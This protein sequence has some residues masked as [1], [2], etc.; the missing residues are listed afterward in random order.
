MK[1]NTIP[2]P[3]WNWLHMNEVIV[4][5]D[6]DGEEQ[7]IEIT[8]NQK[9]LEPLRMKIHLE[10]EKDGANGFDFRLEPKSSLTVIMN[11]TSEIGIKAKYLNKIKY[12]CKEGAKLTLIQVL[13]AGDK[14]EVFHDIDGVCESK[15]EFHLI[16]LVLGGKTTNISCRNDLVG[17]EGKATID[18][19]YLL[20]KKEKLDVNYVVNHIG[21]KT[22]CDIDVNGVLKDEA[23]KLFRGTIDFKKGASGSVG[24]EMEDVL[25][26][27]EDIVNQSLPV[28]LCGEED[29]EGNHGA[30]IGELNED[31]M[32][33]MESR[34]IP[35]EQVY[36]TM[37]RA[38]IDVIKNKIVDE[39]TRKL[40][41]EYLEQI[42]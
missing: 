14:V 42:G 5:D 35:K 20:K 9:V 41:D 37:A 19:G 24:S 39:E 25:L 18:L 38:R 13:M 27:G 1:I 15:G 7:K 12:L 8:E 2:S 3:T 4:L 16:Q 11:L 28:I 6:L 10:E 32:F 17:K 30:S 36:E 33:Y 26:M 34:G 29:V 31:L 22:T 40:V 21:K 23:H